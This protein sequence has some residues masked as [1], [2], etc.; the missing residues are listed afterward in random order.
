MTAEKPTLDE[1]RNRVHKRRHREIGN[2]LARRYARPAA[3]YGTWIAI[4]LGLSAHQVT[5]GALMCSVSGSICIGTGSR[6]GFVL[7][8]LLLHM[9]FWLDHV[10][11]QVARWRQTASLDGVYFDYMMHHLA[12]GILGFALGFG[13]A[14]RSGELLWTVAGFA[15]ATG[16]SILS[17]HNDCRYKS[18]FQRLKS[19]EISYRIDGGSG[20]RPAAAPPSPRNPLRKIFWIA[21][22]ACESHVV[23]VGLTILAA[24]S[25]VDE[26]SWEICW[27]ACTIAMAALSPFLGLSRIARSIAR[28]STEEEF[29]RWF[30][31]LST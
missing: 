21:Y 15:I 17:L 8:V 18:F 7:G 25:V 27:K 31:P 1:L 3:I 6:S 2:L 16:W 9:A 26:S 5:A 12:G 4:R 28:H 22:K 20:G 29:A 30:R 14:T 10:D 13:L 11:G 19:A 24:I 23:L